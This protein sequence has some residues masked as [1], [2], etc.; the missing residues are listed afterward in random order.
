MLIA[1]A[2]VPIGLV[3]TAVGGVASLQ[4]PDAGPTCDGQVMTPGTQCWRFGDDS[5]GVTSYEHAAETQRANRES[6][7]EMLP[8]G[9]V[10][11]VIG[12]GAAAVFREG[13]RSAAG[14][15]STTA[16]SPTMSSRPRPDGSAVG[17]HRLGPRSYDQSQG[18]RPSLTELD[19]QAR[20]ALDQGD[21][22]T[23]LYWY[24]MAADTGDAAAMNN[25]A[26]LLQDRVSR[27]SWLQRWR[28]RYRNGG[29]LVEAGLWFRKAAVGGNPDAMAGLAAMLRKDGN[30]DEAELWCRRATEAGLRHRPVDTA[31]GGR[32]PSPPAP[33]QSA[34]VASGRSAHN[35]PS[36]LELLGLVM[37]N[38]STANRLI[39]FEQRKDPAADRAVSVRR[40]IE[41]LR[42][43][44]RRQG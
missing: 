44:R 13:T 42:E 27:Q 25:L 10:V 9:L 41:R 18:R 43:D 6:A 17:P 30:V 34:S 8:V 16:A 22:D 1:L 38:H 2:A 7:T 37:G 14:T 12:I 3:L 21:L 36:E 26:R 40:A 29:D 33:T 23:A 20:A 4:D 32:T 19:A 11:L 24:Q 28:H 15:G 5:A 39:D 35:S 31:S